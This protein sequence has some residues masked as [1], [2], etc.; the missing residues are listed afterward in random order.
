MSELDDFQKLWQKQSANQSIPDPEQTLAGIQ[1]FHRKV[2]RERNGLS[3]SFAFTFVFLTATFWM[4]R[5]ML[6]VIGILIIMG[7]MS[8]ILILMWKNKLRM[9]GSQF[10]LSNQQ[11]LSS[12]IDFIQKRRTITARYMPVYAFLLILGINVG[13][14]DILGLMDL[15]SLVRIGVHIG[16]SLMMMLFFYI[17]I[18]NHLKKF[19]KKLAPLLSSLKSM[20]DAAQAD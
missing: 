19:D 11:F 4:Y 7:A 10:E 9:T 15:P 5:D 2:R 13:Y 14:I 18:K 17:G 1:E 8:F 6:Y 3:L 12:N 20:K 16:L